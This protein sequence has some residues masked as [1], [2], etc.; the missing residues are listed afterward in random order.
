MT[1]MYEWDEINMIILCFNCLIALF[2]TYIIKFMYQSGVHVHIL[3]GR[4]GSALVWH[5][6]GRMF[7]PRLL[8]Q[9]MR[10]VGLVHTVQYV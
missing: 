1:E 2:V 4:T 5:T 7:E 3:S 9:V 6:R 10:F 8:Q